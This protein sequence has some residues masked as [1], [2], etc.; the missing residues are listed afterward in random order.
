MSKLE[1]I[2]GAIVRRLG[3]FIVRIYYPKIK[4][5]GKEHM[6]RTGPVLVCANHPNSL[7]DPILVGITLGRPVR[8]MAKAPLFKTP[9]LGSVMS[10]LGMI[11]TYRGSD[12]TKQ[13]RRNL[14]SLD[15][16]IQFL[17]DGHAVGIFPEGKSHDAVQVEMVRSGVARI[18]TSAVEQG[19]AE[20]V[21]LPVGLNYAHKERFGS[22]VS[23][24]IGKP[25]KV[26]DW[27]EH[28]EDDG[29]KAI[30]SLTNEVAAR[31]KAVVVHLE[32]PNWEP[33]LDDLVALVNTESPTKPLLLRKQ[34]ADAMNYFVSEDRPRAEGIAEAIR[35][36][37]REVTD[38]GLTLE[39][40]LLQSKGPGGFLH[41]I[42]L[43]ARG[44]LG[45]L[46]AVLGLLFHLIPF[47]IV[48][49]IASRV[50][51]AGRTA[52]SLYRLLAGMPVYLAWYVGSIFFFWWLNVLWP[53]GVVSVLLLPFLGVFALNY[54][55]NLMKALPTVGRQLLLL[56]RGT[57]WRLLR[58]RQT[59]LRERLILMEQEYLKRSED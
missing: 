8:F 36:H 2:M 48:R 50:T 4:F 18:S 21:V 1:I 20:L 45:L 52:V 29:R 49:L 27:L 44:L 11:P 42:G 34:I 47:L 37:C 32:E 22:A 7:V 31:L 55:P 56:L 33:L 30:R 5:E 6:P 17:I 38:C 39:S 26:K 12:D 16:S 58:D 35:L 57:Q 24:Q 9:V 25:I 13:V 41:A 46:P 53:W 54:W 40:L 3:R 43:I 28:C 19:A 14:E 51:P 10:G 15:S 23:V 59:S